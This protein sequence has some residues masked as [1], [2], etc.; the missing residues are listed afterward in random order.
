MTG[1][2]NFRVIRWLNKVLTVNSTVTVSSPMRAGLHVG[3]LHARLREERDQSNGA[4]Q[5]PLAQVERR[6]QRAAAR[7]AALQVLHAVSKQP[8]GGGGV[9]GGAPC[10]V[11]PH[12]QQ[13]QH[14]RL[15]GT[16]KARP[17]GFPDS[18]TSDRQGSPTQVCPADAGMT[19]RVPR[20]RYVRCP[21]G[22]VPRLRY[23]RCPTG[24][25]PRLRYVR[26]PTGRVP[27]LRR[28]RK[29]IK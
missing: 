15:G 27:R 12:L 26:C 11:L 24:R 17:T 10:V 18:G 19:G 8:R 7:D 4:R 9:R 6:A 16:A 2:L 21:T 20:L 25:V 29:I 23:V 5:P 1:E 3:L 14:G 28:T 22:R 13:P